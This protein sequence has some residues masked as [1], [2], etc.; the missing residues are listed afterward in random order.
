M[1]TVVFEQNEGLLKVA[2]NRPAGR[3]AVNTTLLKALREGLKRYF[4]NDNIKALMLYGQGGTFSAGADI[5]ELSLLD[6]DGIRTFHHL[7]ESTF[8]LLEQFPVPTMAVI[9]GHALGTGLEL[10]LCCDFRLTH[11]DARLGIPAARLGIVESYRY[12]TRL[13][14]TV[15]PSR[16]RWMVY[17][18]KTVA[19]HEAQKIG[20]VEEVSPDNDVM[21]HAEHLWRGMAV[22]SR[23]ALIRSKIV[24]NDCLRDPFLMMVDDTAMPLVASLATDECR[25]A[26]ASFKNRSKRS[27]APDPSRS[28]RD[29]Q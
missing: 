6:E 15:G 28:E 17:T 21:V 11:S 4:G 26:L 13:V 18:G 16:S 20:L 24:I 29:T 8:R 2:L 23:Y 14:Q 9:S 7:R 10:S 5:G 3:N 1:P 19:G 12:M 25:S 22:N 27:S